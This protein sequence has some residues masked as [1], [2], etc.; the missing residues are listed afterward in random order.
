MSNT[1]IKKSFLF[2]LSPP[3]VRRL[4][5]PNLLNVPK[6]IITNI[7]STIHCNP[8]DIFNIAVIK[9]G[10]TNVSFVFSA[11][12]VRYVYRHPGGTAGH[13]VN[14]ETEVFAQNVAKELGV[15][16]SVIHIDKT[17]WKLSYYVENM[18][19]C[20]FLN[21]N[22]QL[23]KAMEYIRK[24]QSSEVNETV[25]VFDTVGEAKK[26]MEIACNSKGNLFEEF[27]D[28]IEKVERLNIY[29]E[30]DLNR[31][32]TKKV[33]CHNDTYE[34]NYLATEDGDLYL[35]DWEYAGVNDPANDIACI[36]CRA[37]Y[38][39]EEI[40]KY[41]KAYFNRDLTAEEHR[42]YIAYIAICGFYWFCWGLYKGSVGDDDGFFFLPAY[43]NC[44]R[45]IDIALESYK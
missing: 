4:A 3:F 37:D 15:D 2:K 32:G 7:C 1:P 24:M 45:Y 34:P 28:L 40:E 25:K 36:L 20:D 29:V 31:M 18:V 22:E 42:H 33:L 26:L 27:A 41:L 38:T 6:N 35:I 43:R 14:R 10:L 8:N 23:Y 13:L 12:G 17:G 11:N 39:D 30:E 5:P 16:K 9:A 19:D 21:N 44:K